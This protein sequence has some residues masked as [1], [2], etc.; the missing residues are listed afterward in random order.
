MNNSNKY[1]GNYD[2]N[3]KAIK[4]SGVITPSN[5][6]NKK[7]TTDTI[8]NTWNKNVNYMPPTYIAKYYSDPDL[9]NGYLNSKNYV[10]KNNNINDYYYPSQKINKISFNKNNSNELTFPPPLITTKNNKSSNIIKN[11]NNKELNKSIKEKNTKVKFSD[12]DKKIIEYIVNNSLYDG[13]YIYT[14]EKPQYY[15]NKQI[16]NIEIIP[17][18][19]FDKNIKLTN[20]TNN[21]EDFNNVSFNGSDSNIIIFVIFIILLFIYFF[22][23]QK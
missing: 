23:N 22:K 14:I 16:K 21:I 7:Y 5:P 1:Y 2:K 3:I 17:V 4:G 15:N 8:K 12:K 20:N 10:D 11:V 6:P 19:N 13:K 9:T 18:L